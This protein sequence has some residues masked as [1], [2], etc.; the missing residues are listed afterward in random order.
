MIL[1]IS[2]N[3]LLL[4]SLAGEEWRGSG[5]SGWWREIVVEN[6]GASYVRFA[7][8]SISS[9]IYIIPLLIRQSMHGTRKPGV[10]INQYFR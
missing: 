2:E 3:Y 4:A 1:D 7:T 5:L 9:Y 10:G 6:T 8:W